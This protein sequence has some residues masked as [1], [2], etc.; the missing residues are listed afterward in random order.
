MQARSRRFLTEI[1]R[2][3]SWMG[4]EELTFRLSSEVFFHAAGHQA[5]LDQTCR[6]S[7]VISF[8]DLLKFI[9]KEESAKLSFIPA[10][11]VSNTVY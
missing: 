2:D 3:G 6:L 10:P 8:K 5:Q 9:L 7:R 4:E 1:P 11:S